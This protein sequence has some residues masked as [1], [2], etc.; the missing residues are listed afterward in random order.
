[1]DKPTDQVPNAKP[2]YLTFPMGK[3]KRT[4]RRGC[5]GHY[6]MDK[7]GYNGSECAQ[8]SIGFM[9]QMINVYPMP[10]KACTH[11]VKAYEDCM[12]YEGIP[13]GLHQT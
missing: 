1:M 4:K 13:V 3:Q 5:N 8:V 6:L 10:S 7:Q 11:I 2:P 12:R 9:S